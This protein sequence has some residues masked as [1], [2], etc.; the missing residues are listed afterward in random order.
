MVI[1]LLG[2][3]PVISLINVGIFELLNEKTEGYVLVLFYIYEKSILVTIGAVI[4]S[5]TK[6]P[7]MYYKTVLLFINVVL[8]TSVYVD[9]KSGEIF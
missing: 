6:F 7:P 5:H 9:I 4:E 2:I 8:V 3:K 1:E